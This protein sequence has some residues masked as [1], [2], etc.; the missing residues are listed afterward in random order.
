M[1]GYVMLKCNEGIGGVIP[2]LQKEGIQIIFEKKGNNHNLK[3]C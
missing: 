3:Y 2:G 1:G